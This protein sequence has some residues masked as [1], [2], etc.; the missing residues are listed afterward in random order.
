MS[1][2][3]FFDPEYD[4]FLM[5]YGVPGQVHGIR[6]YQFKDGTWTE[7]GKERRRIGGGD[8]KSTS[9]GKT[10]KKNTR[11]K[12]EKE[13]IDSI[14]D[15][16]D[17]VNK[18][19]VFDTLNLLFNPFRHNNC[20]YCASAYEFRRRGMNV[21]AK[22]DLNGLGLD[23]IESMFKTE[24]DGPK[25]T[26]LESGLNRKACKIIEDFDC[27]DV[28][29]DG[30][31]GL[32]IDDAKYTE[33]QAEELFSKVRQTKFTK[34]EVKRIESELKSHGDGSRGILVMSWSSKS[35]KDHGSHACNY[36][37]NGKNIYLIDSQSRLI[38]RGLG[39]YLESAY[40][41]SYIRTD[42]VEPDLDAAK[43]ILDRD[44]KRKE[45]L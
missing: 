35:G 12:S 11:K 36:E 21:T 24:F 18:A 34:P 40:A 15:D 45:S 20:G 38:K 7:L 39:D 3:K 27:G 30:K 41:V 10:V 44:L 37:V 32:Y 25:S 2:Y 4:D 17:S 1:G 6:N 29:A 31:L 8:H 42:N 28:E 22:G 23:K 43:S 33:K 16:V 26:Y 13:F 19:L 5:H 14:K 9:N